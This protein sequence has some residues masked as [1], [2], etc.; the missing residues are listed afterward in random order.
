MSG[1]G[2]Q[3]SQRLLAEALPQSVA[4]R[5][6]TWLWI[7]AVT[8]CLVAMVVVLLGPMDERV[9]APGVVRPSDYTLVFP[10]AAGTV[11]EVRAQTGS[12]VVSGDLL[13]R[14]DCR[15]LDRERDSLTQG[16]LRAEADLAIAQAGVVQAVPHELT[17]Q[18][19]EAPRLRA[20]VEERRKLLERM[21]AAGDGRGLSL[22]ELV[23]ERLAFQS[24]ERELERA[25]RVDGLLSGVWAQA[26]RD[27]ALAHVRGA[28]A[29]LAGLR[30]R[31]AHV[32]ADIALHEIRAPA[33]G[34]LVNRAVRFQGEKVEL[35][36]ALFKIARGPG[37]RLRLYAGEDRVDRIHPGMKVLFRPKSDPDR[38]RG[39]RTG[40]VEEV[41]LDRTLE[42]EQGDGPPAGT[43]A[44]DVVV[45]TTSGELPL[46]AS[47]EA[48][49]ILGQRSFIRLLMTKPVK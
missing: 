45:D 7:F 38:L 41:A 47:V 29:T 6:M 42:A 35:G 12:R 30:T 26:A 21:E 43:Y 28:E 3:C 46:G 4:P 8:V 14:L 5:W 1:P 19:A 39:P 34:L 31:L 24:L 20:M 37:T 2:N 9:A 23:R 18:A 33:D 15:E 48:E 49:V 13:A 27:G 22:V 25:E 17:L 16:V 10:S 36:Q 44:I 11:A 40:V 32:Q